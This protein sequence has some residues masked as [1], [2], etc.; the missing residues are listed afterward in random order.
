MEGK[1]TASRYDLNRSE[2]RIGKEGGRG[3]GPDLTGFPFRKT[4]FGFS[5]LYY[6]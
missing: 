3:E 4:C 2:F 1:E 6:I 5:A